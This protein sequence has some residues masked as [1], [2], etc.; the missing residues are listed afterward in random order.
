MVQTLTKVPWKTGVDF[1]VEG[2]VTELAS[3]YRIG[4]LVVPKR[5]ASTLQKRLDTPDVKDLPMEEALAKKEL[6]LRGRLQGDK[7]V[8][9]FGLVTKEFQPLPLDTLEAAAAEATGNGFSVR[10][11][12]SRERFILEHQVAETTNGTRLYLSIDSGDF[13]VYGGNGQMAVRTGL[14]AYNPTTGVH[15]STHSLVGDTQRTIHRYDAPSIEAAIEATLSGV[16]RL[17]E[18]LMIAGE[19]LYH[20][21]A[22]QDYV[23]SVIACGRAP[24]GLAKQLAGIDK[25]TSALNLANQVT[26]VGDKYAESTKVALQRLGGE[27]IA[28]ARMIGYE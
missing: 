16:G 26:A 13:G 27:I 4:D 5:W 2:D 10:Y 15:L 6:I 21:I 24:K 1:R 3:G 23:Q 20:P 28:G 17:S 19:T 12:E 18:D 14:T 11:L 8:N 7:G 22:V 9:W 25:V